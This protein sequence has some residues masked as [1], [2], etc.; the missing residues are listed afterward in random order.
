M[1]GKNKIRSVMKEF[2]AGTL[3]HG[4]KRGKIVTDPKVA[5]AIALSEARKAGAKIP[6]PP[7][8]VGSK[9]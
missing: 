6:A 2:S 3:H 4:S 9:R 5:K 1:K 8:S 7:R